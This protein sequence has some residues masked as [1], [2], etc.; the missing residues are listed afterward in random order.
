MHESTLMDNSGANTYDLDETWVTRR[1]G[2]LRASRSSPQTRD[3]PNAGQ[4]GSQR[5]GSAGVFCRTE[6]GRQRGG[7]VATFRL[8]ALQHVQPVVHAGDTRLPLRAGGARTF[9]S[10]ATLAD[11]GAGDCGRRALA[12]SPAEPAQRPGKA[13]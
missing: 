12:G 13:Y 5:T 4:T 2:Q 6:E 1:G 10:D 11:A 8:A 3:V 9:L 7:G